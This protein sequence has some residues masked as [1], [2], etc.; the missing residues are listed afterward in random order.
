M[1]QSTVS[2]VLSGSPHVKQ[3][4]ARKVWRACR[5]LN[6]VPNVSARSLRTKQA[7]AI[8]VHLPLGWELALADPF[9]SMFL[10]GVHEQAARRKYSVVLNGE[11]AET[12]A[13][14]LVE[15]VKSHRADGVILT[16]VRRDDPRV[17]AFVRE[18]VP[19]VLGRHTGPSGPTMVC[20]DIDNR[21]TGR[22]A[23]RFL[24]RA[25]HR[26]I[27]LVSEADEWTPGE[28]FRRGL[29]RQ[30]E[31]L[32]VSVTVR[33]APP[34]FQA[35]RAAAGEILAERPDATALIATTALT[36]FGVIEAVRAAG[37]NVTV[38]G[39]DSPLLRSLHPRLPRIVA[40]VE[41]MGRAMVDALIDLIET[42]TPA[43]PN[44][45][46]TELKEHA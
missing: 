31:A 43:E 40:P 11:P 44:Y 37:R 24:H 12:A 29:E 8:A 39:V 35:A 23:V 34:T 2:R 27:G 21:L 1:N 15:V 5:K 28:E 36:V 38:L 26:I 42:G 7:R 3:A 9:V 41:E 30:A 33:K 32:G 16:S 46:Q 14:E 22:R 25:A 45:L 17:E 20:V 13:N 4:T 6:Y 10:A 19:C 18:G